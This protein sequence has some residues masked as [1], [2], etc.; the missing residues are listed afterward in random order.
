[1]EILPLGAPLPEQGSGLMIDP[2]IWE[3]VLII[4]ILAVVQAI[5]WRYAHRVIVRLIPLWCVLLTAAVAWMMFM[6]IR[7]YDGIMLFVCAFLALPGE[8]AGLLC[9]ALWKKRRN[10][11]DL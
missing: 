10:K 8:A 5:L 9:G 6:S 11:K 3:L 4:T 1:M 2:S 7:P